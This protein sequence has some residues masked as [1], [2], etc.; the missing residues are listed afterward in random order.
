MEPQLSPEQQA[1]R[2]A[3]IQENLRQYQMEVIRTG[4]PPLP[5]PVTATVRHRG[6]ALTFLACEAWD[7]QQSGNIAVT[8]ATHPGQIGVT[9]LTPGDFSLTASCTVRQSGQRLSLTINGSAI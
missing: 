2:R 3:E 6:N 9:P 7:W 1:Q 8:P 4:M 5:I